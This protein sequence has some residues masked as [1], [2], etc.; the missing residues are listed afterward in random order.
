[1]Y[2]MHVIIHKV[3][4]YKSNKAKLTDLHYISDK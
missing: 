2:V 1:M 3:C 4:K